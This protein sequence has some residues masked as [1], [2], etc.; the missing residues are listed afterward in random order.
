MT[1]NP[2]HDLECDNCGE[3]AMF[4]IFKGIAFYTLD[5]EGCHNE[6]LN[7]DMATV[8]LYCYL[9]AMMMEKTMKVMMK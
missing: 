4:E 3:P 7:L 5:E 1:Y 9:C 6:N 2:T 8:T